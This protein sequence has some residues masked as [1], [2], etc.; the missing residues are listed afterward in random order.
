[1]LKDVMPATMI[2][3]MMSVSGCLRT[4]AMPNNPF[5]ASTSSIRLL[6]D[7]I[8]TL[9]PESLRMIDHFNQEWEANCK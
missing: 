7:E 3:L 2:L 8:D 1:M 5:C 4:P 9:T 6:A